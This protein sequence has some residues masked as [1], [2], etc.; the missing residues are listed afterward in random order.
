MR[1][2]VWSLVSE[3]AIAIKCGLVFLGVQFGWLV[4]FGQCVCSHDQLCPAVCPPPTPLL[5]LLWLLLPLTLLIQHQAQP[6]LRTFAQAVPSAWNTPL[7]FLVYPHYLLQV[8]AQIFFSELFPDTPNTW[9][10]VISHS[11]H[12][13]LACHHLTYNSLPINLFTYFHF[14]AVR[15]AYGNS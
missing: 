12:S 3:N 2:Y 7:D 13:F 15:S 8:F 5:T 14:M 11:F 6:Y 4:L 9:V 1:T 10:S